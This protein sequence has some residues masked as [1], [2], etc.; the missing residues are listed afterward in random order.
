MQG[1]ALITNPLPKWTVYQQ[2]KHSILSPTLTCCQAR[3]TGWL[4]LIQTRA[5]GWPRL[6]CMHNVMIYRQNKAYTCYFSDSELYMWHNGTTSILLES[7]WTHENSKGCSLL[8]ILPTFAWNLD[9]NLWNLTSENPLFICILLYRNFP[10]I[11]KSCED[12]FFSVISYL[13]KLYLNSQTCSTT[14]QVKIYWQDCWMALSS[15]S[16]QLQPLGMCTHNLVSDQK[17][18][19]LS[20]WLFH[21]AQHHHI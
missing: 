11:S 8:E 2:L 4:R 15:D 9:W 21:S 12:F 10:G 6:I 14:H 13:W 18:S 5:T 3:N 7:S 16:L 17:R 1:T 20:H 19:A